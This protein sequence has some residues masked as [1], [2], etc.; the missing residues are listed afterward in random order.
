M[1]TKISITLVALLTI[2]FLHP[3]I[4]WLVDGGRAMLKFVPKRE[5]SKLEG[6]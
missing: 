2:E 4:N 1:C 6:L 3:V 5:A